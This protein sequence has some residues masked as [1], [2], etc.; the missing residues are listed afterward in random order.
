[1]NYIGPLACI[2]A[3]SILKFCQGMAFVC[4]LPHTP[5][6]ESKIEPLS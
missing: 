5:H 2:G 4:V 6:T 1:M 3:I